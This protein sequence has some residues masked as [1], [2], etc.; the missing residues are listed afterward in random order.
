MPKNVFR[1]DALGGPFDGRFLNSARMNAA[2]IASIVGYQFTPDFRINQQIPNILQNVGRYGELQAPRIRASGL[3]GAR[4]SGAQMCRQPAR[5]HSSLSM[6]KTERAVKAGHRTGLFSPV[7]ARASC[8]NLQRETSESLLM[9][10]ERTDN[11]RRRVCGH[12]RKSVEIKYATANLAGTQAR[13]YRK[14]R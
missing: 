13:G 9:H 2:S 7:A 12:E 1:Y 6:W 14:L 3:V 11:F 10:F 8:L 4:G 5:R